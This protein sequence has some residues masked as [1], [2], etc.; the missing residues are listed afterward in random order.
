MEALLKGGRPMLLSRAL[1]PVS[2]S[3]SITDLHLKLSAIW[4]GMGLF[5]LILLGSSLSLREVRAQTRRQ[6]VKQ[7]LQRNTAY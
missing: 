7:R 6:E 5:Y 1:S 4:G 3:V 2:Q